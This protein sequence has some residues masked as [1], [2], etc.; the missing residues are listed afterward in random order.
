MSPPGVPG[1]ILVVLGDHILSLNIEA[2][3]PSAVDCWLS[4][5][6]EWLAALPSPKAKARLKARVVAMAECLSAAKQ[7]SFARAL[8]NEPF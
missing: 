7:A 3:N 6:L 5:T 1:S 8:A 2:F 4:E